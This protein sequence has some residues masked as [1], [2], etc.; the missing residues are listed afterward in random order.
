MVP[1]LRQGMMMGFFV[2]ALLGCAGA[3]TP[4][5]AVSIPL[6]QTLQAATPAQ[7]HVIKTA[8]SLLDAPYRYGGTTPAGFDCSGFLFYVYR[9]AAGVDLPRETQGMIQVGRPVE[10]ADLQP[11]DIV[12]FKIETET[13]LH[14]G[15]YIGNGQFI[16]APSSKGQVNIQ[17]LSLDYWK[18]SYFGARRVLWRS[19][20]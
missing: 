10:I 3:P 12:Y 16:H 13:S 14:A 1:G 11:A 20:L 18:Q 8:T 15:I 2:A 6:T 5:P 9:T 19:G 7:A 4:K 17:S